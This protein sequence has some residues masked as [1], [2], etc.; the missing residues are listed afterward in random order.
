MVNE[1]GEFFIVVRR[2]APLNRLL[3]IWSREIK[4]R[5]EAIHQRVR[6]RFMGEHGIDSGAMAKEFFTSD[7]FTHWFQYVFKWAEC[8][9][10]H[11]QNGNFKTCGEIV[12]ASLAQGGPPVCFL[13][14]SVYNMMVN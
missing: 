14:E 6:V 8:S 5:P 11:V 1:F 10:F 7:Y 4:R 9:T 2:N 3:S 12:A 13:A